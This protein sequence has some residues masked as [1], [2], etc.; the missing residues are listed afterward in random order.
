MHLIVEDLRPVPCGRRA[1][2]AVRLLKRSVGGAVVSSLNV[3]AG[4]VRKGGPTVPAQRT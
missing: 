2:E 3:R 4:N 1:Q